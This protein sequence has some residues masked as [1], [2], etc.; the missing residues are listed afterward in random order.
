MAVGIGGELAAQ[1]HVGL[2]WILV[3]VKTFGRRVPDIDFNAGDRIA[4]GVLVPGIGEQNRSRRRRSYDRVPVLGL[5]RVH[6]PKRAELAG[7]GFGL[8]LVAVIE[9]T[10]E[11]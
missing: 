10:D 5:R 4:F 6:P 2:H 3:L 1:V 7:V 9:Q 8:A 11:G